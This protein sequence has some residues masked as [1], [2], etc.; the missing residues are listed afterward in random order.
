[1]LWVCCHPGH[2]VDHVVLCKDISLGH[3]FDLVCAA[4]GWLQSPEWSA[5]PYGMLQ[6][7]SVVACKQYHAGRYI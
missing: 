6:I 5:A 2:L 4:Y 3:P 1:M 7:L